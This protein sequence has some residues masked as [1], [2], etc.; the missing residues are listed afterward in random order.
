LGLAVRGNFLFASYLNKNGRMYIATWNVE[1][2][3]AL[4]LA[5]SNPVPGFI[6][7]MAVSPDGKTVVVGYDS[8]ES[9]I[10]FFSVES[11]GTLAV[12]KINSSTGCPTE[13]PGSPFSSGEKGYGASLAAWPPRPF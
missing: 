10:D 9:S 8:P 6:E 4:S 11:D 1:N 7:G 13:V 12:Y 3:C 2:G 5:K